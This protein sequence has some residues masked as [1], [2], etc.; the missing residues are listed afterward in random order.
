MENEKEHQ[1]YS[2][3]TNEDLRGALQ[4]LPA[5]IKEKQ[6]GV[7]N[8]QIKKG[9]LI[10]KNKTIESDMIRSIAA[11]TE[12][13]ADKKTGELVLKK[14]YTNEMQRTAQFNVRLMNNK[15]YNEMQ[16][17]VDRLDKWVSETEIELSFLK[18]LN[19]NAY[20]LTMLGIK[21]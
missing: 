1:E 16:D 18:R 3:K 12:Q 9:E 19:N 10:K 20:A 6:D 17:S 21:Y 2:L 11:E 14:K 15:D 13:V 4:K 7:F 8:V 5:L